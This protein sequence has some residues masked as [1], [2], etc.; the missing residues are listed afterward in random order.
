MKLLRILSCLLLLTGTAF[1]QSVGQLPSG[2]LWG[3]ATAAR[4]V[5]APTTITGLIDRA[6]SS[7]QGAMLYRN[8]TIW[9]ALTP[10]T[11]GLPLLSGGAGANLA[12]GI[13]G[14]AAGGSGANM[15]ASNGGI[16]YSNATTLGIL[17]GTATARQMLQSGLSTTPAW[18]TTTWP[19]TTTI[20]RILF[21]SAANT[22]GEISTVNGGIVNAN[23]SGVPALTVTPVLGV[24][25]AST[26]TLGFGGITSG[27]VTITPQA[28]AGT[29]T[30]TLPNASGTFAVSASAP[31]ALSATTGALTITGAAGQVLAGAT[32]A[33]TATPELGANGGT[34][35]QIT[36]NGS[37]SGAAIIKVAAAA[38]TVTFQLPATNG[39]NTNV[40]ST[41]GAGVLSW[42]SAG[43]GTVTQVI[44][45]TGLTGGT[46]TTTG[47]CAIDVA[48]ASNFLGATSNKILD[49]AVVYQAETTSTF[50]ATQVLDFNSFYNTSVTL[51][52]N[53]TSFSCSNQKAGQAGT[54]RFIQDATGSRTLPATMG[55]NMKFAGGSQPVLTT[56]ANAIDALAYQCLSSSYCIA[57]L[58]KNVQ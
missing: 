51:T 24:P 2:Q 27:T 30:L 57:S 34:G 37:T 44:C 52:A 45:G 33:F 21:S 47:T 26:G 41:D 32:P 1:G 48:L 13:L 19:A 38:G 10:G 4:A 18:S 29:P 22:I 54:I 17:S 39:S 14:L 25:G 36:L 50:N 7:T 8:G 55:C 43:S 5:A 15:T 40:L 56:T 6:I 42:S 46:I 28:A 23:S 49:A 16:V 20:N 53:I 35:G 3:N 9:T 58:I 12:Y 31:L 11:L